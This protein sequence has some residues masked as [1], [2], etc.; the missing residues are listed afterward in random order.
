MALFLQGLLL[1]WLCSKFLSKKTNIGILYIALPLLIAGLAGEDACLESHL[2]IQFDFE[3]DD[4]VDGDTRSERQQ[5]EEYADVV[6]GRAG[7]WSYGASSLGKFICWTFASSLDWTQRTMVSFIVVTAA[8][9]LFI[10]GRSYYKCNTPTGRRAVSRLKEAMGLVK[11]IPLWLLF[12]PYSLVEAARDTL[13]ILQSDGLDTSINP[14]ITLHSFN[15]IPLTSLYVFSSFISFL[16]STSS[17]YLIKKLL[18][19]EEPKQHCAR[20]AGIGVGMLFAFGSSLSAWLVEVRRSKLI[21]E[22]PDHEDKGIPMKVLWLAPQFALIGIANGLVCRGLD[23]FFFDRVPESKR[24]FAIPFNLSVM[25]IGSFL[26]AIATLLAR[27]W[28]GNTID[29][30]R[31]DKYFQMLAILNVAVV[32]VYIFF[33]FMFDWNIPEKIEIEEVDGGDVEI[34]E[35]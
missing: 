22:F 12:I 6:T 23:D 4:M 32:P 17:K 25:G 20:S 11:L 33:S 15:Q 19:N 18:R 9:I 34:E 1:L 3:E 28:I 31:L 29:E 35:W 8:Y 13:F 30:S 5:M 16:V 14:R 27:D 10:C 26:S 24:Y 21:K 2:C 7:V